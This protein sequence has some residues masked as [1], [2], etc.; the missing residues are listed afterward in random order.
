MG[1]TSRGGAFVGE[2]AEMKTIAERRVDDRDALRAAT[3]RGPERV[4]L[5][6]DDDDELD[7]FTDERPI[8]PR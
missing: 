3:K 8:R 5:G 6:T 2:V 7:L 1:N 4:D